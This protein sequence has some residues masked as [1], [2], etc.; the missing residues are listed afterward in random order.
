MKK[1]LSLGDKIRH[2]RQETELSQKELAQKVQLSDKTISAY[3]VDRAKPS[4]TVLR[5]IG[6]ATNRPVTYFV[7]DETREEVDF[8]LKIKKIEKELKQI[9]SAL[10]NKGYKI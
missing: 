10:K 5:Q 1:Q 8:A 6:H 3:E 4:V 2:A 9:K 7:D